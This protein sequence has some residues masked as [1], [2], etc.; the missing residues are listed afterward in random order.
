MPTPLPVENA[1]FEAVFDMFY[2]RYFWTSPSFWSCSETDRQWTILLLAMIKAGLVERTSDSAAIED[3][4]GLYRFQPGW[5]ELKTH[6]HRICARRRGADD[7]KTQSW[8]AYLELQRREPDGEVCIYDYPCFLV[9]SER[10]RTAVIPGNGQPGPLLEFV[11]EK[12]ITTLLFVSGAIDRGPDRDSDAWL[13]EGFRF[14]PHALQ[15]LHD[16]MVEKQDRMD[17]II[18][19]LHRTDSRE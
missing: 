19:G 3:C 14:S 6:M 5:S 4:R 8:S 16:E 7:L 2:P 9:Y 12:Q 13:L 17:Q 11:A 18:R 1:E 10:Q 15:I